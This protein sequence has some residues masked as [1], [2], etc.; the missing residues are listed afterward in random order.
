[1]P[2]ELHVSAFCLG[3][4]EAYMRGDV[5]YTLAIP[6][7]NLILWNIGLRSCLQFTVAGEEVLL[8]TEVYCW[9]SSAFF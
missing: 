4:L 1:M 6:I 7:R 9:F 8:L 5:R 2:N 3:Q